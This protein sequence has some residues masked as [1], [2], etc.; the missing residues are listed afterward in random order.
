MNVLKG[1][2]LY[3]KQL[4]TAQY[5][6]AAW[7][8]MAWYRPLTKY[9]DFDLGDP[10]VFSRVQAVAKKYTIDWSDAFQIVSV[11]EGFFSRLINDSKTLLV[12]ADKRLA[13]VARSENL[14]A[15]ECVGELA[16]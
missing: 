11:R 6:D 8:L 9:E 3:Q 1:K 16:P 14:R 5:N 10:L 4:T 7:S 13:E 12:T 15:W 2:W